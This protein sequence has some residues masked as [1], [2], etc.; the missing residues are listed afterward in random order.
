MLLTIKGR[1]S[2][3]VHEW[4]DEWINKMWFIHT[5]KYYLALKQKKILTHA[6]WMNLEDGML[7]EI[8]LS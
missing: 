1:S 2:P 5:M 8:S 4:M 7:S 3:S 6:T